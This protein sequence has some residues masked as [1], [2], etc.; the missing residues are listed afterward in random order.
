MTRSRTRIAGVLKDYNEGI[1]PARA[2]RK[3]WE[4]GRAADNKKHSRI[5]GINRPST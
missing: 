3:P 4:V 1:A 2:Y 5:T